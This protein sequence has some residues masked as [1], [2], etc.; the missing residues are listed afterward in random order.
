MIAALDRKLLRDLWRVRSMALAISVVVAAGIALLIAA[1]ICFDSLESTRDRYYAQTGF[2]DVFAGAKRAPR[3]L[4]ESFEELPGV[5]KVSTR[6]VVGVTLDVP[7]MAEPVNG[8]LISVPDVGRPVLNDV[9]LRS[10]RWPDPG[11]AEEA[12]VN[13]RF[14]E[15]HGLEL[16][17]GVAA[18]ING[19][20][21]PLEIVGTV[22]SPEY[23]YA[24]SGGDLFPD[25]KRF[26]L[27]WLTRRHLATAFDMEGGFNDISLSLVEG[28]PAAPA[29]A[30]L[31]QLIE[32]YGGLGAI[33]RAL[34]VSHWYLQNEMAGLRGMA[35]VLP[36]IFLGIAA[37]LLNVVLR[38]MIAVQREQIA[39]LKALGYSNFRLGVHFVQW[40]VLVSVIGGA[41]GIGLGA[42]MSGA[43][44]ALYLDYFAFPGL[45][46]HWNWSSVLAALSACAAA[47]VL[48]AAAAVR[49]VVRLPPAEAMRPAA[50]E[51]FR[52]SL[53]ERLGLR[54][55]LSQ[56][57]RMVLRNL[58]RRPLRAAMSIVG[59][60]F[61]AAIMVTASAAMDSFAELIELQFNVVQRQDVTVTFFEPEG[62]SAYYELASV[63][64]VLEVEATNATSVRL[65]NGS[66][67][68]QVAIQALEPGARLQRVVGSDYRPVQL[69][70]AGLILSRKLAE[71]LDVTPGE[72]IR[73]EALQGRRPV[74]DMAVGGLVDDLMGMS[75]YLEPEALQRFLGDT[76]N[77]SGAALGIDPAEREAVYEALKGMP[78]VAG[79]ALR[80]ATLENFDTFV[81]ENMNATMAT[82][83]LFALIIAFGVIYNTARISLSESSR[84]LASMRVMGF[85]R[86]EIG[87]VL[88]GEL[89]L[90]TAVAI[91]VGLALG[92]SM[93]AGMLAAFETELFRLPMVAEP[94]TFALASGAVVVAMGLSALVVRHRLNRLDLVEVLKTRE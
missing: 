9:V 48:G 49:S 15:A 93:L 33:P 55:F 60:A 14:A 23:V 6:V 24:I 16:G 39:V 45:V 11:R 53:L 35:V 52:V 8:R 63:P 7:G 92:Y 84:E 17:D 32:P 46:A 69:D 36:M 31:D 50:P 28:A 90:L 83:L 87:V 65:R 21:Q 3:W 13:E 2:A 22:L 30:Q 56:P 94:G 85:T 5:E 73:V 37:F 74:R 77:M 42:L 38:R 29:I 1:L 79:V 64:G 59:I 62:R 80:H 12:L 81:A 58:S 67:Q 20:Y 91:P 34:Q 41:L 86:T 57:I 72:T 54:R 10:G 40:A 71:V 82:N 66:R 19:R 61:A 27:F 4:A 26:G 70:R 76:A 88:F 44:L 89:G 78:V 25:P 68:R 43:M 18:V 51:K 75:A 47:G